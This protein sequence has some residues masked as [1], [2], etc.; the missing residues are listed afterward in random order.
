MLLILFKIV[1][2][3][4]IEPPTRGFSAFQLA[5]GLSRG[6][7]INHLQR[8]ADPFPGTPRH[9]P[10]TVNLSW[11][12]MRHSIFDYGATREG[13]AKP[14]LPSSCFDPNSSPTCRL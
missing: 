5:A 11:S 6:L 8:L 12:H 9:T 7:I 3:E 4:E 10:G 13:A 2:R 1:A 14:R